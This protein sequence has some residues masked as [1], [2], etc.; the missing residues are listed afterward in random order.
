MRT[1]PEILDQLKQ[2][3]ETDIVELLGV[4]SHDLI[5]RFSDLIESDP[6]KFNESLN[7]WFD[8]EDDSEGTEA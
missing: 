8:D 3:D 4:N 1:L 2:L 7:Q 5:N 6:E